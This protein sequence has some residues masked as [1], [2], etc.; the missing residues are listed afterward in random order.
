M[1]KVEGLALTGELAAGIAHEIRNP[2]AS[3]SGSIQ[4]LKDDLEKNDVNK[5]LM[6]IILR[7]INR[8]NDLVSDFL[9]FAR[10]KPLDICAFNFN[11]LIIESV[12]LFK[13]SSKWNEKINIKV[14]INKDINVISDPDQIRQV[15]WN[16]LLNAADAIKEGG[17]IIIHAGVDDNCTEFFE[18]GQTIVKV[19]VRDTG[20]GF[21][22]KTLSKIFT[23]FFTTKEGGSGLGLAIVSRIVTGLK[24]RVSGRNHPEGGAEITV[25]LPITLLKIN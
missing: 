21:N 7:E 13:N 20:K 17:R 14:E 12:E 15:L 23:P 8:L 10:P 9:I 19:I 16:I 25:M 22:E 2:M 1:R 5:R 11:Q 24:G 6:D 18:P 3:I 4:M